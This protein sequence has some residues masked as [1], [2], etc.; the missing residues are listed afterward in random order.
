MKKITKKMRD[1]GMIADMTAQFG[2]IIVSDEFGREAMWHFDPV[3][4]WD[5]WVEGTYSLYVEEFEE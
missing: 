1:D 5:T 4:V 2:A 3:D